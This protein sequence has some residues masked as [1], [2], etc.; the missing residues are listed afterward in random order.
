M[1]ARSRRWRLGVAL[2]AGGGAVL[3]LALEFSSGSGP[4]RAL[5][6]RD[7]GSVEGAATAAEPAPPPLSARETPPSGG[8]RE[9]VG[10]LA[11]PRRPVAEAP[12]PVVV[13]G[14][15]V[16]VE[17]DGSETH[18]VEGELRVTR[19][20]SNGR[21]RGDLL[22]VHEGAWQLEFPEPESI[23]EVR[24]LAIEV[25]DAGGG[26]FPE[27]PPPRALPIG[28]RDVEI[29]LRR[30]PPLELEV[31][32]AATGAPLDGITVVEG[33]LP[34]W[35]LRPRPLTENGIS[36]VEVRPPMPRKGF[37]TLQVAARGHAW[38]PVVV[39]PA[40]GGRRRV[41]LEPGG[42]LLVRYVGEERGWLNRIQIEREDDRVGSIALP[43]ADG[44]LLEHVPTGLLSL[45]VP[46]A[47]DASTRPDEAATVEVFPDQRSEVVVSPPEPGT[48]LVGGVL[49]AH[50]SWAGVGVE[51]DVRRRS[52]EGRYQRYSTTQTASVAVI[53]GERVPWELGPVPADDYLLVV[54]P[55]GLTQEIEV[56]ATGLGDVRIELPPR[57]EITVDVRDAETGEPVEGRSLTWGPVEPDRRLSSVRNQPLSPPTGEPFRL[58]VPQVELELYA[59]AEGHSYASTS[60]VPR[61]G[62][63]VVLEVPRE[64]SVVLRLMD[65]A[66]PVPWPGGFVRVRAVD[67]VGLAFLTREEGLARVRGVT[68]GRY[69][70]EV[71]AIP[72]YALPA[73]VLFE[74]G[75]GAPAEVA[76]EMTPVR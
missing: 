62:Q 45:W 14:T 23:V 20:G 76:V 60:L 26:V 12:D 63:E 6:A 27:E 8:E 48:A 70:L 10:T 15:V 71:P 3:W 74:L 18:A 19:R 55:G 50:S 29:R 32:D 11:A 53:G 61:D 7:I 17:E 5:P 37:V 40:A 22:T 25:E 46:L 2:L 64:H 1:K 36:P 59:N 52:G 56:P 72:G 66:T 44:L 39:D 65:G 67:T 42:E 4:A 47:G 16:I 68:P 41:E 33:I 28:R 57:V 51:I 21:K 69:T 13:A 30:V 54:W 35:E 24:L 43:S 49:L 9:S 34:P 75:P 31:V 73:P 38:A 58:L